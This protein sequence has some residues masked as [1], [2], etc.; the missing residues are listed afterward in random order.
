MNPQL[1]ATRLAV[2]IT[3]KSSIITVKHPFYSGTTDTRTTVSVLQRVHGR[4]YVGLA[5]FFP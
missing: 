4:R 5:V 2:S 1:A 3:Q